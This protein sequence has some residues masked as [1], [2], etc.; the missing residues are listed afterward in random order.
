MKRNL[1]F[2][3]REHNELWD[4]LNRQGR[5]IACMRTDICWLK[6]FTWR[7]WVPILLSIIGTLIVVMVK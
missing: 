4:A 5:E 3:D 2:K 1:T 7:L 6:K